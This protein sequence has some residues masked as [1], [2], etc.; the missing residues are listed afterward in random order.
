[1]TGDRITRVY[2]S[3]RGVDFRGDD[4]NLSRSPDSLN[5]WKDY[6]QTDSIRTRPSMDIC[7]G[8]QDTVYG[9]FFFRDMMIVHAGEKLYKVAEDVT[10]IFTSAARTVSDCFVYTETRRDS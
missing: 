6:R 1:M 4:I 8:F 9:V 2:G 5:M 10:E 7:Q 3:F